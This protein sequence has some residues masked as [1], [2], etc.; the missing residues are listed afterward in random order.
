[1]YRGNFVHNKPHGK[2]EMTWPD[3]SKYVGEFENGMM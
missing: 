2:G 3:Q 1:M